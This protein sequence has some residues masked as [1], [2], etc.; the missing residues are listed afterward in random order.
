MRVNDLAAFRY[1]ELRDSAR[2]PAGG[3]V[4]KRKRNQKGEEVGAIVP[5]ITLK[6]TAF[7][8]DGDEQVVA[9]VKNFNSNLGATLSP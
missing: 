4:Y 3:F 6:S 5:H 2:G 8:L 9:S 1:Y 7:Y